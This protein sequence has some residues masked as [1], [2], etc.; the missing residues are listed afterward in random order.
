MAV[1]GIGSSYDNNEKMQDFVK[2]Q[3]ACI[4]W[5]PET[6]PTYHSLLQS[7]SP[8]DLIFL[9]SF[10]VSHGL[11]I[12]AVGIV[13]SYP[14]NTYEELGWGRDV[15]WLWVADDKDQYVK[16][17]RQDDKYDQMRGGTIY[18]EHNPQVILKVIDKIGEAK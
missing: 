6:A 17:G 10:P 4:G 2:A 11:Y 18:Q 12:K 14:I 3:A 5:D 9:K 16:L 1:Y 7:M 13:R 8:G 15:A